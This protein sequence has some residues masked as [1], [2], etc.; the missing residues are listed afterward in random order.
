MSFLQNARLG[1]KMFAAFTCL[2]AQMIGLG[3]YQVSQ[4]SNINGATVELSTNWLPS[5]RAVLSL[6]SDINHF[7]ALESRYLLVRGP[8]QKQEIERALADALVN[9]RKLQEDYSSLVAIPAERALYEGAFKSNLDAYLTEHARVISASQKNQNDEAAAL[10]LGESL[11]HYEA[12]RE[13]ANKLAEFNIQGG[14]KTA[15]EAAAVYRSSQ[16]TA[17]FALSI[18]VLLALAMALTITRSVTRSLKVAV[19]ASHRLAGGDLTVDIQATTNDETGELL[20]A[21]QTMVAKLSHV[22]LEV[23]SGADALSGAS[24]EVS[25]TAQSLSQASSE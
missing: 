1:T 17:G 4:L 11:R 3:L 8:E 22:I 16:I 7:R 24:E 13:T 20:R 25:A 21:M 6:K 14:A 18:S 5:I 23:S 9:I 12:L 2:L 15:Q 10:L 19:D